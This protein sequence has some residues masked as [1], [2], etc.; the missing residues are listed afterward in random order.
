MKMRG[1][2]EQVIQPSPLV[3]FSSIPISCPF[4]QISLSIDAELASDSC[5]GLIHDSTNQVY[6][7]SNRPIIYYHPSYQPPP[8]INS[9]EGRNNLLGTNDPCCPIRSV[10]LHIQSPNCKKTFVRLPPFRKP[11]HQHLPHPALGITLPFLHLQIKPLDHTFLI[12]IGVR[13]EAGDLIVIRCSTFQTEAKSYTSKKMM[14]SSNDS[15]VTRNLIHVPITLPNTRE[16]KNLETRWSELLVPLNQLTPTKYKSTEF[17]QVHA[18]IRLRRIFFT[19]DGRLENINHN[20]T[21]MSSDSNAR[22][23]F[24]PEL[25][26][27]KATPNHAS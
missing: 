27:F 19:I 17:I 15:T 22:S 20:Q 3:V 8:A 13:D 12:E 2:Y 18:N 9:S 26:L 4:D 16:T 14:D 7:Q 23:I 5:V 25:I 10:V 6:E 21:S 11:N 24:R 1:I